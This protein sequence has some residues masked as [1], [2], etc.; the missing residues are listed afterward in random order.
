MSTLQIILTYDGKLTDLQEETLK[1]IPLFVRMRKNKDSLFLQY[2]E[3][4]ATLYEG[5]TL[6]LLI[7]GEEEKDEKTN[8]NRAY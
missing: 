1:R 6:T 3:S 4:R 2:D 7:D 5:D 8:F